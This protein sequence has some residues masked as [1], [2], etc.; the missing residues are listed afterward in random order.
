MKYHFLFTIFFIVTFTNNSFSIEESKNLDQPVKNQYSINSDCTFS[1]TPDLPLIESSKEIEA[2]IKLAVKR[3]SD[4][5][6]G[7]S[8]LDPSELEKAVRWYDALNIKT[9]SRGISGTKITKFSKVKFLKIFAQHLKLNPND[10]DIIN[11]ANNLIWWTSKEICNGNLDFDKRGYDYR[12]FGRAAILI[13][14]LN[15]GK[16]LRPNVKK[17]FAYTLYK[18]TNDLDH[19][20]VTDYETDQLKNDAIDTDQIYNKSDILMTYS[21]WQDTAEKRYQYMRAFQRYLKR[22]LTP[23][24]GVTNGIKLDGSGFHH[25]TAYNSYMYAYKT[26]IENISYLD[27]TRFQIE[28]KHYKLIRDAVLVQRLQANDFGFQALSTC[29]RKPK[30]RR[31]NTGNHHVKTLAIAGGHI[32]NLETEDPILAGFYN[33]VE[34]TSKLKYTKVTPFEEGFIQLNYSTLGVFR[35]NNWVAINKGFSDALW[36]TEAYPKDNR[37]GRYQSYGALEILYPGKK[38]K[39]NGYNA[40]TWNW[41]FSPGTTVITL[42]WEKLHAE[43]SR[44]DENQQKKF[45]GSLTFNKKRLD[46]LP[47]TYGDF[48]LFAMDFKEKENQGFS[49]VHGPNTHNSS[50]EFKKSNFFFDDIIICLGSNITNNDTE[51]TTVTTL[52][53]RIDNNKTDV[54]VNKSFK[55]KTGEFDFKG[56]NNNWLISNYNTGFYVFGGNHTL[57]IKKEKQ[58]APRTNQIWPADISKNKKQTYCIGYLDHGTNPANE[59]YEYILKPSTTVDEMKVLHSKISKG[60][61]PYMVHQKNK[62]AHVIEHKTKE[63][64]GYAVFTN[65]KDLGYGNVKSIDNSCLLMSQFNSETKNLLLSLSNPELGFES[66]KYA[67]ATVKTIKITLNGKWNIDTSDSDDVKVLSSNKDETILEFITTDGNAYEVNLK[68]T[69]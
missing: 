6:L 29:G 68:E 13:G 4:S 3:F 25:W 65:L 19:Y 30:E 34:N 63:I 50:F 8:P 37:Y 35:K 55:E 38:P 59:G 67:K 36:G 51:N 7:T 52:Y 60:K 33:R 31:A 18:T 21:L 58:Q 54:Y 23:S 46:Y 2:E 42:P 11:K 43:K 14:I 20:W 28:A 49:K 27:G 24:L 69:K 22:F 41:N 53:Q 17:L 44:V 15:E 57:K 9:S 45:V 16:I 26:A 1:V 61:K 64:F 66:R 12:F 47:N 32:L 56:K 39:Q 40:G 10:K 62:N 48:G 5:Y